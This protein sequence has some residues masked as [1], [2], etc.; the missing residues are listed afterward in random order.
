MYARLYVNGVGTNY[1]QL[2]DLG[3]AL[4]FN[5]GWSADRGVYVETDKPYAG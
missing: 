4:G 5:V 1:L 3:A 2:R